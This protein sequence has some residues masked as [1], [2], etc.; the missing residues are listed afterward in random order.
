MHMRYADKR[1]QRMTTHR[2]DILV[3]AAD[4]AAVLVVKVR[5][6]DHGMCA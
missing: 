1:A 2:T 3:A 5:T 4:G 6:H